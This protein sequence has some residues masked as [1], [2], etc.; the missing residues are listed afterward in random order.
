MACRSK[1]R[2][3]VVSRI[4]RNAM[5]K[6]EMEQGGSYNRR[7]RLLRLCS[8]R[9]IHPL[10]EAAELSV[11]LTCALPPGAFVTSE[12]IMMSTLTPPA[13]LV[14]SQAES[15]VVVGQFPLF[16]PTAATDVGHLGARSAQ[17]G[18]V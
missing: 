15:S 8:G 1:G 6:S 9:T 12:R 13:K 11:Q 16:S 5:R 2:F 17:P 10:F 4:G 14:P 7:V 18:R 3:E